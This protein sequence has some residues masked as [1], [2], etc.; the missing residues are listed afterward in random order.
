MNNI[1]YLYQLFLKEDNIDGCLKYKEK[2]LYFISKYRN[3]YKLTF[4]YNILET[5]V[6]E[7]QK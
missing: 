7:N 6:L 5:T 3:V 2:N 4:R 1:A